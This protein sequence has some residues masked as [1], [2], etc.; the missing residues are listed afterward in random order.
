MM[1]HSS[2]HRGARRKRLGSASP[3]ND[4]M[5]SAIASHENR[6][7]WCSPWRG[8][9][10]RHA[11]ALHSSPSAAAAPFDAETSTDLTVLALSSHLLSRHRFGRRSCAPAV[12]E[13]RDH[14]TH[15]HGPEGEL[16]ELCDRVRAPGSGL[17]VHEPQYTCEEAALPA[18]VLGYAHRTECT[19]LE[20][21]QH[22]RPPTQ[23]APRGR[24]AGR[25]GG[26]RS[27]ARAG[28]A[29]RRSAAAGATTRTPP[30]HPTPTPAAR[31][32]AAAPVV[33]ISR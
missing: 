15:A 31:A 17:W 13:R 20:W 12:R 14:R 25:P 3:P 24:R 1:N 6:F 32:A 29:P 22:I 9:R 7:L 28:G 19:L 21:Y 26:A 11:L 27:G 16:C 33:D 23:N 8:H 2:P 10:A 30:P 18:L 5:P 4:G